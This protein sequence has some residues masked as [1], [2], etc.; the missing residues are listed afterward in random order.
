MTYTDRDLRLEVREDG[1]P[2]ALDALDDSRELFA[3]GWSYS[4]RDLRADLADDPEAL[5][6]LD[7]VREF[8]AE[9]YVH[10]R[11]DPSASGLGMA[12]DEAHDASNEVRNAGRV[13]W[14]IVAALLVAIGALGGTSWAERVVWAAAS[15]LATVVVILFLFWP[16][17]EVVSGALFERAREEIA[18][19]SDQDAGPTERL[20]AGKAVDVAEGAA[21]DVAGGVR[22]PGFVVAAIALVA[23]LAAIFVPRFIRPDRTLQEQALDER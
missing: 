15:L 1:G 11:D 2:D 9:G 4:E 14:L 6:G 16:V 20:L 19:W 22:R 3:G 10:T 13:G 12:L 5:D 18:G 23:L 8:L 7:R 17:Y 21:D